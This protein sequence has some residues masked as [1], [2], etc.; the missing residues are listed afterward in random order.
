MEA[1]NIYV[2][3]FPETWKEADLRKLFEPFGELGSVVIMKDPVGKGKGFG[4][5]CFNSP[6]AATASLS[7]HNTMVQNHPLYVV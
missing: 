1:T 5:V 3:D 6:E 4:F 2:K 7:L